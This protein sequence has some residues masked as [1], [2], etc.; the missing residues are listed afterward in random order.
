MII[1]DAIAVGNPPLKQG[2]ANG[3]APLFPK[4]P[5]AKFATPVYALCGQ[6]HIKRM[7]TVQRLPLWERQQAMFYG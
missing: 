4:G 1:I 3:M 6:S 7:M 5:R 2:I